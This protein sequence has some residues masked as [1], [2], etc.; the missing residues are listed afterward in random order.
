MADEF[1]HFAVVSAS[2]ASQVP[3]PYV[4][5][6]KD[7]TVRELRPK[8]RDYLETPFHPC[9]GGRPYTKDR[10]DDKDGW[11]EIK[12]FCRRSATPQY[13]CGSEAPAEDPTESAAAK[14]MIEL[15]QRRA[16]KD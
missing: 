15:Y 10:Y 3:Y 16:P 9:D 7:G 1:P 8:E 12:G 6:N 11:G 13:I 14:D 2:E 5:V 4:Y